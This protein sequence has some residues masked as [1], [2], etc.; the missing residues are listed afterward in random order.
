MK[1]HILFII[2]G[3]NFLILPAQQNNCH[4]NYYPVSEETLEDKLTGITLSDEN[5]KLPE[6][7]IYSQWSQGNILL[8]NGEVIS[9]RIIRYDGL[10]DQLIV[11]AINENVKLAVERNTIDGFDIKMFNSD[12]I[13]HYKRLPVKS[14]FSSEYNDGFLQVLVSG[15]VSLYAFRR[16]QHVGSTNDLQKYYSYVIVKE[17]GYSYHFLMYS[18][19]YIASLF[20]EKKDI[21]KPQLRKQHN[22]IRDEQ[23]LIKAIELY[24]TL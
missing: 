15:K 20:P 6:G 9:N 18:R 19:R 12:I 22:R 8:K 17:D 11:S 16:I 4:C 7:E 21:F 24:N 13:L 1:K 3:L 2:A 23:E 10:A 5:L 14:L